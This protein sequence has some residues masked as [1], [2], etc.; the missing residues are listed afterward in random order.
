VFIIIAQIAK[1]NFTFVT[2]KTYQLQNSQTVNLDESPVSL[3]YEI[4]K[5]IHIVNTILSLIDNYNNHW[6]F[7]YYDNSSTNK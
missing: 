5:M 6:F 3:I 2:P 7:D 4:F 1:H